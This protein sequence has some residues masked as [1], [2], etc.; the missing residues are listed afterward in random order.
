MPVRY[1]VS[2]H[3]VRR[4][5][6]LSDVDLMTSFKDERRYRRC[7]EFVSAIESSYCSHGVL[8]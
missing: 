4:I 7:V 1:V 2:M 5:Y 3:M 8:Q 6:A